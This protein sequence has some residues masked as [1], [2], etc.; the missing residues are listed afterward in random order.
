M[1]R[2]R[3]LAPAPKPSASEQ[4]ATA[5][6]REKLSQYVFHMQALRG[7]PEWDRYRE[8]LGDIE[9]QTIQALIAS[10]A[11]QHDYLRG[12]IEGIRNAVNMPDFLI[13][14]QSELQ[15]QRS[16]HG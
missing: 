16:E 1:D 2:P 5:A 13:A 6:E 4:E 15:R 9:R 3:R 12:Y 8:V 10:D 14:K 11:S 7:F